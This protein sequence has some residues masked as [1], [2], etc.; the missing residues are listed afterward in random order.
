MPDASSALNLRNRPGFPSR[1]L[2]CGLYATCIAPSFYSSKGRVQDGAVWHTHRSK[3][4]NRP[5]SNYWHTSEQS[6]NVAQVCPVT[7]R[8]FP[9]TFQAGPMPREQAASPSRLSM[10]SRRIRR[11]L[12]W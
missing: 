2:G 9:L 10:A 8:N 3:A 6:C 12:I 11:I 1:T 4:F 5:S 7:H